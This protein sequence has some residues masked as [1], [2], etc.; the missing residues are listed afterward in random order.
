MWV[1]GWITR[2]GVGR[3][4]GGDGAEAGWH[5]EEL[6]KKVPDG[7]PLRLGWGVCSCHAERG[8]AG[9]RQERQGLGEQSP[10]RGRIP[11]S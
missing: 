9:G 8:Q 5:L 10:A 7:G 6:G 4:L 11:G 2:W 3:P 1:R